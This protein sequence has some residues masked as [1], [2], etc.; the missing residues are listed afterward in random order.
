MEKVAYVQQCIA[1]TAKHN[2]LKRERE[3]DN[4]TKRKKPADRQIALTLDP[5]IS[6]L[7]C[8]CVEGAL[9]HSRQLH[10]ANGETVLV[11]LLRRRRILHFQRLDLRVLHL[12]VV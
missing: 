5:V 8:L 12:Y 9:D 11:P 4:K 2:K 1:V 10:K 3:G 6:L 7:L